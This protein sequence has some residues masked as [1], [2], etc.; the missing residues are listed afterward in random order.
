MFNCWLETISLI[1]LIVCQINFSKEY[2][3]TQCCLQYFLQV[4]NILKHLLK[5]KKSYALFVVI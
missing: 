5:I 2:F 1:K 3:K 4:Y